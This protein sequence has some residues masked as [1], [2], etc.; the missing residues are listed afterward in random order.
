[1]STLDTLQCASE[2]GFR[3][4]SMRSALMRFGASTL[5]NLHIME[6][7]NYIPDGA[8]LC[9]MVP[10][11]HR[12]TFQRRKVQVGEGFVREWPDRQHRNT[13]YLRSAV[14]NIRLCIFVRLPACQWRRARCR[15]KSG[16]SVLRRIEA[17]TESPLQHGGSQDLLSVLSASTNDA[18]LGLALREGRIGEL[19]MG[20]PCQWPSLSLS[21]LRWFD[22]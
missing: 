20:G 10:A 16:G 8:V 5:L 21:D 11:F 6:Y 13:I 2:S 22:R 7:R 12:R 14:E 4:S 3:T 1:M 18:L 17:M 9:V 15:P 19:H